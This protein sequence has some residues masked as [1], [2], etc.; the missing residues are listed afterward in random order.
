L[1]YENG[2]FFS[3]LRAGGRGSRVGIFSNLSPFT[4]RKSNLSIRSKKMVRFSKDLIILSQSERVAR[5]PLNSPALHLL[6]R[7]P[8]S[9]NEDR[10]EQV[11]SRSS[12]CHPRADSICPRIIQMSPKSDCKLILRNH[13]TI[14][15]Y[16]SF[17]VSK[18]RQ[19]LFLFIHTGTINRL[20]LICK[21]CKRNP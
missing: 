7:Y 5:F 8:Q 19:Y 1:L 15:F 18:I 14:H 9:V 3:S 4:S 20:E 11:P 21:P 12:E 17:P 10:R 13:C 16:I 6:L 2:L